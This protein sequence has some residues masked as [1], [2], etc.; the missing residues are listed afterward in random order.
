LATNSKI[1]VDDLNEH[2]ALPDFDAFLKLRGIPASHGIAFA[3]AVV[4]QPEK[5]IDT[6][7]KIS[8]DQIDSELERFENAINNLIEEFQ[9]IL[10]KID[11]GSRN[12]AAVIETSVV[13]LSDPYLVQ[14]IENKIKECKSAECAITEEFSGQIHLLRQAK[15]AILRERA[16]DLDQI[17]VRL[18][19]ILHHNQIDYSIAKD[20]IVIA[21]SLSPSDLVNFNEIGILGYITE[22]G[23]IASHSSILAR[24]FNIPAVI[25]VKDAT[26]L[27]LDDVPVVLDAYGGVI[28]GNPNQEIIIDYEAK[29]KEEE[30]HKIQLGELLTLKSETIDGREIKLLA[31][32]DFEHEAEEALMAGAEGIGLL[33]SENLILR[34]QHFPD[35]DEQC[36]WY[37]S[38]AQRMYPNIVT[39]RAFDVGTDKYTV[40]S[41]QHESNPALGFRGI[42]FLLQRK[43][44]FSTQIRAVLRASRNKNVRLMLPMVSMHNELIASREL[45]E[46][47]KK[48]LQAENVDFD[49]MIPI[50]I[51][52]ETPAAALQ[53]DFLAQFCDFFSI[54]TNDLTQYTLAVDRTNELVSEM[55]EPFNPAVLRLIKMAVDSAKRHNISVSVCGELAGHSAATGLLVGMGVTELSVVPSMILELKKKIRENTYEEAKQISDDILSLNNF[56]EIKSY[57]SI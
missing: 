31:N 39:I 49:P 41:P 53:S 52:I 37:E 14:S 8:P 50:G 56:R 43:D 48:Q 57:L 16:Q 28:Y 12:V 11:I 30:Q 21:Q 22:V 40:G 5:A 9:L 51:M 24:T 6:D 34:L 20:K 4:I 10:D 54:G 47:C 18:L 42:R 1:I 29:K 46:K 13:I 19:G 17:K 25:G 38:I 45:I 26:G 7:D 2:L 23:G 15:D 44:I 27:I 35:E 3:P 33:R 36:K 55:Y 32:A